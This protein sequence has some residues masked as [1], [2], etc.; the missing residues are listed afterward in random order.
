M[1]WRWSGGGVEVEWRWSGGEV[2]VEW[3]RISYVQI[4]VEVREEKITAYKLRMCTLT[5]HNNT[6]ID[7]NGNTSN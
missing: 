2:E 6:C 7:Y 1:E 3:R 5:R 4:T